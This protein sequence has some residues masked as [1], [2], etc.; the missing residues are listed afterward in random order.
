MSTVRSRGPS[1]TPNVGENYFRQFSKT[2]KYIPINM[3]GYYAAPKSTGFQQRSNIPP[4]P[5][6][7]GIL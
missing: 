1:G 4:L 7:Q 2:G 6:P 3:L 5:M